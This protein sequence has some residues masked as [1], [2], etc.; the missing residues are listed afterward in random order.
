MK[1]TFKNKLNN[2]VLILIILFSFE[3]LHAQIKTEIIVNHG[4]RFLQ[5]TINK[6]KTPKELFVLNTNKKLKNYLINF[7][8]GGFVIV[9][10]N[11]DNFSVLG[12]SED[13]NFVL[14]ENPLFNTKEAK[15]LSFNKNEIIG[16]DKSNSLEKEIKS[17]ILPFM[18]DVWG[19]V[20]CYNVNGQTIFPSN[21]YTP[22]HCSPGCV[23]IATSQV[24]HYYEWPKLGVGNNVFADNYN[25]NLLRHQAFFDV[26]HYDWNN[27]LDEYMHT[28]STILQQKALGKL[29]YHVGVAV[30]MNYEPSGS[31]NNLNN[32]PFVLENFFRFSGHYEVKTWSDFWSRLY[33]SMQQHRPVPIAV[34]ASSTGDGHVMVAN[35][36]KYLDNKNYYYINWG[37]WNA[38]GLNGYYNLQGWTPS[39]D[40]YNTVIGAIF[41]MLPEPAI[42]SVEPTGTGDDFKV[43][44]KVSNRLV[45]DEFTLE[46][47][48]DGGSWEVVSDGIIAK[49]YTI[50]NPTG[51]VY[52]LRVK[53]KV[54]GSYYANSYSEITVYA[55]NN[56]YNGYAT[57]G[58]GQH[59]FARQTP[60]DILN[61][62]EDYT[63]E[64]WLRI[65]NSNQNGDVILDQKDVFGLTIQDVTSTEYSVEFKSFTSG[66][67]LS[68][69]E[70]GAKL[71]VGSWYHIAVSKSGST[72]RIFING[73][74]RA[75]YTGS[76]FNL[77][78]SNNALNFGEKYRSNYSSFI[79]ADIDQLRIS[80]IGRY[81]T[82]FTPTRIH[83]F[84]IDAQTIAYFTFQD[85]H[86]VRL[87]DD[88]H[89]MSVI[90][91]NNSS[92]VA[93]NFEE[94]IGG[95]LTEE[96][97]NFL[98][99]HIVVYPNPT[100]NVIQI[101]C[102]ENSRFD[103]NS[104]SFYL[105][106]INGKEI[107]RKIK[108]TQNIYIIKLSDLN[109]G[110]YFLKLKTKDFAATKRII[111]Q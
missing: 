41:D 44:W 38:Y 82:G 10:V 34:E 36:Y 47:K 11:N 25:G 101:S 78:T 4:T 85:V 21:Y 110:V 97:Q 88:M 81:T 49:E 95:S 59:C 75:E 33:N 61:F 84:P 67:T 56:W 30:K 23:A 86:R 18:T 45:W 63:F 104:F 83:Q 55:T 99:N 70:S 74:K 39:T 51:T 48:V 77:T 46:Q 90:A 3:L 15:R 73:N 80:S 98:R 111:K 17:D 32:I 35:G 108:K 96:E 76:D 29:M 94:S 2:S 93:W 58:G 91:T 71:Q 89:Q 12:F 37:W 100:Q 106:D 42:Y 87:L 109:S 92:Y 65:T 57:F 66:S 64:T 52:Q 107:K 8:K 9:T 105:Y 72:T 5:N 26:T 31:T 43:K 24:L 13:H 6:S 16:Y 40:G 7:E 60:D 14:D 50:N 27:I 20:N 53:A 103:F 28:S 54:N 69:N 102:K 68:S 1:H 79:K 22:S 19:G 62:S